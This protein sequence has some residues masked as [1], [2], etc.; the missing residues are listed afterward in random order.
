[1]PPAKPRILIVDD[2]PAN[3]RVLW[4]A[5]R[6]DHTVSGCTSG[7][8]ALR[9]ARSELPPDL[10]LLDIEMPGMDGYE[11]CRQLKADPGTA[12]IPV[13]FITARDDLQDEVMGLEAGAV[14][15]IR[16]PFSVE[17]ARARVRAHVALKI[18]L[19]ELEQQNA[20]LREA[21]ILKEDLNRIARHDLKTPLCAI[22]GMPQALLMDDNLTPQ[23]R[24][25][26][27]IIEES[28]YRML[29]MINLS[30]DLYKM[31]CGTYAFEAKEVDLIGVLAKI[32]TEVDK[33]ITAKR[34][35]VDV[36]I[37]GRPAAGGEAF[38]VRGEELLCYTMLANLF[39]N[40]VEASP[41][42]ETV[43]VSFDAGE[44]VCIAIHNR[45]AV[46]DEIRGQFFCKH[47]TS[48]KAGGVG[49]GTY[50]A[51]LM[52]ETQGGRVALDTTEPG[53]TTVTVVLPR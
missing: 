27:Q 45:G 18:A 48:G 30:L 12:K 1:M 4:E 5:L 14:D 52:A 42:G 17:I 15:Y 43:T 44:E 8:E 38:T 32:R 7:E 29:N 23:Q 2:V 33:E 34:L 22:I 31:E 46:P 3:I 13:I 26:C 41:T 25:F 6:S 9:L 19:E 50:S 24:S 35:T 28:G 49:L 40:A 36:R 37:A 51:K 11:V 21:E 20:A 53:A 10:I 39:K 47:T 16:K